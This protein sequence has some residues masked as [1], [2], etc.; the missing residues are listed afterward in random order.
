MA[1]A[2]RLQRRVARAAFGYLAQARS[3]A[4]ASVAT[5]DFVKDP[6]GIVPLR[7]NMVMKFQ[8]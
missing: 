2:D 3:D 7:F 6:L 5:A 4:N 1:D 8:V